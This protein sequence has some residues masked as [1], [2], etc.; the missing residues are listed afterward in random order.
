MSHRDYC[1]CLMLIEVFC[2][3][4]AGSG[5]SDGECSAWEINQQAPPGWWECDCDMAVTELQ[6]PKPWLL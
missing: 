3:D 6:V 5:L 1:S 2:L 4:F